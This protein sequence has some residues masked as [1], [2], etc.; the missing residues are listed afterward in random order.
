MSSSRFSPCATNWASWLVRV[1]AS[2]RRT[3]CS[4]S[5]CNAFGLGG[6]TRWC[7]SSPP[8]LTVGVAQGFGNAGAD[9]HGGGREDHASIQNFSPDS[10]HACRKLSLGRSADPRRIAE[11]R[12]HGL[13]THGVAD[14]PDRR[15]RPSQTWRT[16]LANHTGNLACIST[17]TSSFATS[18]DD[19]RASVLPCRR[20]PLSHDG[21]HVSN[22]WASVDWPP[23]R[24]STSVAWRVVQTQIPRRA[25]S[26][27]KSGK[28]P[29]N[30]VA[31][32][33][34]RRHLGGDSR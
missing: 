23:S 28:D 33:M 31:V 24:Q 5:A 30:Y 16:F 15:T 34:C 11:A 12:I 29:P 3:V 10:A 14:L 1:D 4:G 21:Q 7:L 22:H 26:R 2:A 6:E 17:V 13:R 8:R 27:F 32:N 18:D 20:V 25:G 19:L 9:A